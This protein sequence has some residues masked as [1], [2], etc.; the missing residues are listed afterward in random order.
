MEGGI[1]IKYHS[2]VATRQVPTLPGQY[3]TGDTLESQRDGRTRT[4]L[5]AGVA[6]GVYRCGD[7]TDPQETHGGHHAQ[8]G[9]G[10]AGTSAGTACGCTRR[11][12]VQHRLYRALER[13]HAPATRQFDTQMSACSQTAGGAGKRHVAVGMYLQLLLAGANR[14]SETNVSSGMEGPGVIPG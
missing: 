2:Q 9:S 14:S 5:F 12:G 10:H 3:P 6:A 1:W 8:A 4:S 11:N 13:N 7:Q